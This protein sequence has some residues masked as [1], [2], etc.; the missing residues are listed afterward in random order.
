MYENLLSRRGLSFDRL[1]VLLEL[2]NAG[3]LAKAA[4]GNEVRQTQYSRQIKELSEH[5]GVALAERQGRELKLTEHGRRLARLTRETFTGLDDF[6]QAC[7][8]EQLPVSIGAGDSIL[9]WRLLP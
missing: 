1:N 5:F 3:S 2:E 9:Q 4:K 6:Q 8:E 7:L